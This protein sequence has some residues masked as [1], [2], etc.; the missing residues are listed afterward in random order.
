MYV[1]ISQFD[2]LSTIWRGQG[3]DGWAPRKPRFVVTS[4]LHYF[5]SILSAISNIV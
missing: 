4:M 1:C 3:L 2:K 5:N